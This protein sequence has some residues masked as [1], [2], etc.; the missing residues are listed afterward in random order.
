[1]GL[2]RSARP[3]GVVGVGHER[4]T[5]WSASLAHSGRWRGRARRVDGPAAPDRRPR[6]DQPRRSAGSPRVWR[7]DRMATV[8]HPADRP[9]HRLVRRG[10]EALRGVGRDLPAA[11]REPQRR[12]REGQPHRRATLVADPGRRRHD[13]A[14]AGVAGPVLRDARRHPPAR[15]SATSGRRVAVARRDANRCDRSRRRR[16]RRR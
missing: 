16:S 8:C 9:D 14:G 10:R 4:V 11:A 13:R 5:C 1:M 12:R 6:P 3:A 15:R 2:A 7:F